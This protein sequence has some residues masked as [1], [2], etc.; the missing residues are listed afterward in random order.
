MHAD[1]TIFNDA[2]GKQLTEADYDIYSPNNHD[3]FQ[4]AGDE[5]GDK[6]GFK[7][8]EAQAGETIPVQ[9]DPFKT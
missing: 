8:S 7:Y 4:R 1:G 5:V 2:T 3:L 9:Q 6:Y